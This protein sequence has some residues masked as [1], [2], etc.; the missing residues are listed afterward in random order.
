MTDRR[1]D[2]DKTHNVVYRMT[3]YVVGGNVNSKH[4]NNYRPTILMNPALTDSV[5][6]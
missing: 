3:M 6:I 5:I 4:S 1:S 2:V